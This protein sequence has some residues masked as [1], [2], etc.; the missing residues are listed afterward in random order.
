MEK[1]VITK[2]KNTEWEEEKIIESGA[3]KNTNK[4]KH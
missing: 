2:E 3:S 1:Y 4:K